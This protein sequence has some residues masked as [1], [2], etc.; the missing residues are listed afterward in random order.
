MGMSTPNIHSN[1]NPYAPHNTS[2]ANVY[3]ST[4]FPPITTDEEQK[5]NSAPFNPYNQ[6]SRGTNTRAKLNRDIGKVERQ[7]NLKFN[8]S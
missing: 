8:G 3:N 2:C 5:F 1:F 4:Q 7:W 6:N